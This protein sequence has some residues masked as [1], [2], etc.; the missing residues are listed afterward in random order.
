MT[1]TTHGYDMDVG[2]KLFHFRRLIAKHGSANVNVGTR[3]CV[4]WLQTA[5]K[6]WGRYSRLAPNAEQFPGNLSCVG[7]FEI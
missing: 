3:C 2:E 7:T 4:G 1:N 6:V 5:A